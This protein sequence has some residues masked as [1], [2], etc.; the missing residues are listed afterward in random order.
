MKE[1]DMTTERRQ[2]IFSALQ[3]QDA[4]AA[5]DFL[6]RGFGFERQAV[7]DGPGDT[8]AH[9][10]LHL[11]TASIGLSS[12]SGP[13][14]GNP[15]TSTR[16]GVY[17]VLPDAA[18][19]NAHHD[20]AA[21]AGAEIAR[22]LQDTDYGSREYSVWDCERHLWSF[23]TYSHAVP[24]D[25]SL[26]VGL[27]YERGPEALDWLTR[28]FGFDTILE[29]PGQEGVIVHAELR[30]GDSVLMVSSAARD[31]SHWGDDRQCIS[32]YLPEPD[33]H[34]ARARDAGA[35]I[36]HEPKDT[37]YG[38]RGYYARDPEGFLWGFSTYRPKLA[39]PAP[40]ER[41]RAA[42]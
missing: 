14:P 13:V 41:G 34:F 2:T 28:A 17:A 35:T 21:A 9:A 4:R 12:A 29:V 1:T 42:P 38:A 22:P 19:V 31:A 3:Y 37:A 23:G 26:F 27:H 16:G 30:F 11:G 39:D 15:W 6:E 36:L 18:A 24:G 20:R 32:I 5:I 7:Y 25:P 40:T 33:A 8:I 10:E